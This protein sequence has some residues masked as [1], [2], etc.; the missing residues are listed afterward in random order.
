V[1]IYRLEAKIIGRSMGKS[2]VGA[3][4]Y[5]SGRSIVSIAAYRAAEKLKDH[6]RDITF[7]YSRKEHVEYSAILAP[8]GSPDWVYD[9][10][11]LWNAVEAR[12]D[13]AKRP[14]EAQLAREVLVT[15]PRELSAEQ[16]AEL[17]HAFAE[18]QFV[19][20]GM[21][22]D[23]SIHRPSASDGG[24]QP[25]AHILL[26]MRRLEDGEFTSKARDWNWKINEWR[27][28][29]QEHA[30]R[31]LAEAGIAARIDHRSL[32]ARGIQRMP[33]PKQGVA[34]HARTHAPHLD[35]RRMEF[36]RVDH[37]NRVLSHARALERLRAGGRLPP[38]IHVAAKPQ[39]EGRR[40]V[41]HDADF[42]QRR[43]RRVQAVGLGDGIDL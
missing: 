28:A 36:A 29:W 15:L 37:E 10:E 31:A 7:D 43:R 26:T 22:A 12:E 4:A 23:I 25:H 5:R 21:V 19:S 35:A 8:A 39:A 34:M 24:E 27:P 20:K 42:E 14:A 33:Q 18:E 40:T 1:A 9:R 41:S 30:N 32:A 6:S 3:A 13:R 17:V 16:C 2:A 11:K 38:G